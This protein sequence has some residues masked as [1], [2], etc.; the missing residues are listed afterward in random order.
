V[1]IHEGQLTWQ[2][3][4]FSLVV[5]LGKW[6]KRQTHCPL[7]LGANAVRL[8]LGPDLIAKIGRVLRRSIQYG[9]EH[10]AA[11]VQ[12]AMRYGRGID[13]EQADRFIGMYVNDYTLD[14]GPAGREGVRQLLSWAMEAGL[15]PPGKVEVSFVA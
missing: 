13:R 7:P 9:L 14:L 10:R 15:L 6:W 11:G 8:D 2:D 4:G 3:D 1:L 12:H 5:D